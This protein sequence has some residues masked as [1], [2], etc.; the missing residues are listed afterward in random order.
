MFRIVKNH[1]IFFLLFFIILYACKLQEPYK[2]HGIVFLENRANKLLINK[3][4][5]NDV[6]KIIGQPHS[7]S[8]DNNNEWVYFER[9]LTRGDYHKLGQN[10]LKESNVLVLNFDKFGILKSKKLFNK[11]DKNELKFSKKETENELTRKSFVEKF[12]SSIRQK[13]YRNK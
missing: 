6:I 4:N 11:S 12:L 3:S 2:N 8:I 9:I 5:Q 1:K 7:K 10:I 13:M